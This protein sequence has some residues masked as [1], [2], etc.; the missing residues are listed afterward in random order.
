MVV[1]RLIA[2]EVWNGVVGVSVVGSIVEEQVENTK[3]AL[4]C[5]AAQP[6]RTAANELFHF[7]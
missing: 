7:G 1:C 3:Q 4:P 6:S 2:R 5:L